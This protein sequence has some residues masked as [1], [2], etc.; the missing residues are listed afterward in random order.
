MRAERW[1]LRSGSFAG[2]LGLPRAL[3]AMDH[4]LQATSLNFPPITARQFFGA[5]AQ[6]QRLVQ[7]SSGHVVSGGTK[8]VPGHRTPKAGP[9][10]RSA[11]AA[12]P[13]VTRYLR[14]GSPML[15]LET[16]RPHAHGAAVEPPKPLCLLMLPWKIDRPCH[17][18]TPMRE[19][20]RSSPH[21]TLTQRSTIA[22]VGSYVRSQA[23][24][25]RPRPGAACA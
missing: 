2:F 11:P 14:E 17:A 13:R 7:F 8:A 18:R 4:R 21:A 19:T 5:P 22:W 24:E 16:P 15:R 1:R 25:R 12:R 10:V 23:Q 6:I 3:G 20:V 9:S